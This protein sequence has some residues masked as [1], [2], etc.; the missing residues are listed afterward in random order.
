VWIDGEKDLKQQV[1]DEDE[2]EIDGSRYRKPSRS[3]LEKRGQ[4]IAQEI[5]E[6][7]EALE[8]E[9]RAVEALPGAVASV[10]CGMDRMA[11]RMSEAHSDPENA[12]TPRRTAPYERTAPDPRNTTSAWRGPVQRRPITRLESG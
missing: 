2:V 3:F 9:A 6:Q 10:S 8:T 4:Q 12:P 1:T 5:A 11:V 7:A